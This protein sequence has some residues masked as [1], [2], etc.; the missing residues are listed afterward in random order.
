MHGVAL[1]SHDNILIND[2]ENFR[3]N[4]FDND[5]NYK[6]AWPYPSRGGIEV[7]PDD[8]VYISDINE[9]IVNIVKDGVL[10]DTAYA[11]RAHGLGVD[12]DGTVYTSSASRMTVFRLSR[13]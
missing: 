2:S 3:V 5:G 8:I 1:D 4:V 6:E 13:N 12:T 10:I 7:L 9:G 11:P